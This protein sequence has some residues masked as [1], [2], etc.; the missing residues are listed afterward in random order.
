MSAG[1]RFARAGLLIR[2]LPLRDQQIPI[3]YIVNQRGF[4]GTGNAGDNC[5]Y[6]QRKFYVDV[7]Q[8]VLLRTDDLDGCGPFSSRLWHRNRFAIR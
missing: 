8:V 4:P 3:K 5:E 2:R 7:L 6:A 1:D